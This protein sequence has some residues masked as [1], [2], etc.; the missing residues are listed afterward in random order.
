MQTYRMYSLQTCG[1]RY[2]YMYMQ[3]RILHIITH[4][5]NKAA[6]IHTIIFLPAYSVIPSTHESN[7][8]KSGF[9]VERT[10]KG[11]TNKYSTECFTTKPNRL[12]YVIVTNKDNDQWTRLPIFWEVHMCSH[13]QHDQKTSIILVHS[14]GA[15]GFAPCMTYE[16]YIR[17]NIYINK[18]YILYIHI[19]KKKVEDHWTE[20]TLSDRSSLP[21][22]APLSSKLISPGS[23]NKSAQITWCQG[24]LRYPPKSYPP[25]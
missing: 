9:P 7:V 12:R 16:T 15:P 10:D 19:F 3:A 4:L 1:R 6:L 17:Y 2:I 5:T 21:S 25:Q 13:W 20:K 18:Y 23:S 11:A 22:S 14:I 8:T 24:N